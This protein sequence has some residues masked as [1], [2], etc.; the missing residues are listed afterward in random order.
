MVCLIWVLTDTTEYTHLNNKHHLCGVPRST[1]AL[2]SCNIN[3]AGVNICLYAPTNV[4]E[5]F[6]K[7]VILGNSFDFAN[8]QEKL[9]YQKRG[10]IF[11]CKHKI[12][13]SRV[14]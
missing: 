13:I 12:K 3:F 7:F 1:M 8:H 4:G 11:Y 9:F 5:R 2:K 14:I 6:L 10:E